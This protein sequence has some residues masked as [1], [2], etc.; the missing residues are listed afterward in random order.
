MFQNHNN[1]VDAGG[2]VN[3]PISGAVLRRSAS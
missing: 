3:P 1:A 2:A